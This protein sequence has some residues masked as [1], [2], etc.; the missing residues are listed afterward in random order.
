MATAGGETNAF[1][2]V[3]KVI[4]AFWDSHCALRVC[5]TIKNGISTTFLT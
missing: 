3:K 4:D 2:D 1:N 5:Y